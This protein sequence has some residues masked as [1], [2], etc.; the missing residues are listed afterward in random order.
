[1]AVR[2]SHWDLNGRLRENDKNAANKIRKNTYVNVVKLN[3]DY[4]PFLEDEFY[5]H[6]GSKGLLL[7]LYHV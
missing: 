4:V 7:T 2:W 3:T 6:Y 5:S 1:M